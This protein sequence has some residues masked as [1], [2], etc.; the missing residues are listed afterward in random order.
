ML[1]W[2][3]AGTPRLQSPYLKLVIIWTHG[4]LRVWVCECVHVRSHCAQQQRADTHR[5]G[6]KGWP[7]VNHF[8]L[9]TDLW[10]S[11][12]FGNCSY[13]RRRQRRIGIKQEKKGPKAES[14]IQRRQGTAEALCVNK[15][16]K[17]RE[18]VEMWFIEEEKKSKDQEDWGGEVAQQS[19]HI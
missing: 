15:I 1:R 8:P 3:K 12:M 9:W 13:E 19:E 18:D 10:K 4:V 17:K 5:E 11:I 16:K 14:Q 6:D 7:S 2:K